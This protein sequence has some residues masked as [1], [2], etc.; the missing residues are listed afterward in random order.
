MVAPDNALQNLQPGTNVV[1]RLA[2][3]GATTSGGNW[4]VHSH[5]TTYSNDLEITGSLAPLVVN[6]PP[7]ITQPP[8]DTN[9]FAGK[10]AGF[11]VN[12]SGTAPLN[13]QWRKNGTAFAD[14]GAIS[15]AQTNAVNFS[16]AATNHTG[17]YTVVITNLV[18][19]VTS[20]VAQLTVVPL[21]TLTVSNSA[22]GLTVLAVGAVSNTVIVQRAT[23][24]SSPVVWQPLQ[25]NVI[26]GDAQIRFT[27]TNLNLSPV[28]YRIQIP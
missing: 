1:F 21:P 25:T 2:L 9:T 26:G 15:G 4:Y 27:E 18:G 16:P 22:G 8:A 7:A 28:F 24:L 3:S 12:A 10:N 13:F 19:G 17:A 6:T 20:S 5:S 11:A 23:N 14:G